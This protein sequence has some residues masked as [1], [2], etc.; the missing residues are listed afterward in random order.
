[1]RATE[2][3]F[4]VRR[5]DLC[6][7]V[8]DDAVAIEVLEPAEIARNEQSLGSRRTRLGLLLATPEEHENNDHN[9]YGNGNA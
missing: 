6:A 9:D 2:D 8:F 5:P 4:V 7:A 1:V 3:A